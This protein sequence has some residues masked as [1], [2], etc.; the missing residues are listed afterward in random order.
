MEGKMPKARDQ[1]RKAERDFPLMYTETLPR[2]KLF[3]K[4]AN[5][6]DTDGELRKRNQALQ[7]F[8]YKD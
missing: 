2:A 8:N 4:M 3:Q 1:R 6:E 7:T 5:D